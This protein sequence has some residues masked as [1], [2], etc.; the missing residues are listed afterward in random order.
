MSAM[1]ELFTIDRLLLCAV[2][3]VLAYVVTR[4]ERLREDVVGVRADVVTRTERLRED[5]VG[6]RAD[7][8]TRTERLRED[9]VGVR[10][11]VVGVRADV[12]GVREEVKSG[13]LI[14]SNDA[15]LMCSSCVV[16]LT[17]GEDETTSQKIGCAVFIS[18]TTAITAFH[19][20]DDDETNTH[21]TEVFG[22]TETRE[23][24]KFEVI[25][26]TAEDAALDIVALRTK[27]DARPDKP[28]MKIVARDPQRAEP[29]GVICYQIGVHEDLAGFS[30]SFKLNIG[31]MQA[32]ITKVSVNHIF[33]QTATF[34]GDSGAGVVLHDGQLVAMH[35]EGVNEARER[36]GR[37]KV[38]GSSKPGMMTA[39][40]NVCDS[41]DSLTKGLSQGSVAVRASVFQ[42]LINLPLIAAGAKGLVRQRRR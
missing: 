24:I 23:R 42:H 33:M 25:H 8:V 39:L 32:Y 28:Y 18:P 5:V 13:R 3:F 7:V 29:V 20:V 15:Q 21:L 26:T 10:A 38:I 36:I 14:V 6:V 30:E 41:V 12:V 4:T 9:V 16:M 1:W 22:I 31:V 37:K 11:D 40:N 17:D 27:S 2:L 35:L 19:V 34:A